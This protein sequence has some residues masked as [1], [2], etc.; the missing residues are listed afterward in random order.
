MQDQTVARII[1]NINYAD[2]SANKFRLPIIVGSSLAAALL[3]GVILISTLNGNSNVS[4]TITATPSITQVVNSSIVPTSQVQVTG[5]VS[6]TP[7]S[8]VK[9]TTTGSTQFSETLKDQAIVNNVNKDL[10]VTGSYIQ[11]SGEGKITHGVYQKGVMEVVSIEGN[12]FM[13][14]INAV[15]VQYQPMSYKTYVAVSG[16]KIANVGRVLVEKDYWRYVDDKTNSS[17]ECIDHVGTGQYQI[18]A[19]APCGYSIITKGGKGYYNVTCSGTNVDK[20]DEI[21]KTLDINISK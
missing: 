2:N 3:M 12:G 13:L 15:P 17:A 21:V 19:A 4:P 11:K 6:V 5:T 18:N 16:T 1:P 8:T 10:I 9:S 14:D 7:T 20:C